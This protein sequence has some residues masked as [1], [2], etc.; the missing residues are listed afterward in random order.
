MLYI[1]HIETTSGSYKFETIK[2]RSA[3]LV[4]NSRIR[5]MVPAPEIANA[6][7]NI[8]TSHFYD[9]Q[10]LYIF[11]KAQAL[12]SLYTSLWPYLQRH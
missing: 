12:C 4:N 10:H 6:Y 2:N 1:L 8:T 3:S 9:K 5:V 11:A 7:S